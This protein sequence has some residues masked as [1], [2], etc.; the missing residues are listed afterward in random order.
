MV[1]E[2][3][4]EEE[5]LVVEKVEGLQDVGGSLQWVLFLFH[6]FSNSC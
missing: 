6:L 2:V 3:V 4:E 1:V 5:V